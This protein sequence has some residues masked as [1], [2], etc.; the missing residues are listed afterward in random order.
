MLAATS[1]VAEGVPTC[2]TAL[3]LAD[4]QGVEM[5]IFAALQE[6]LDGVVPVAE[7]ARLLMA[8]VVCDEFEGRGA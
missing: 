7:A 4:Q 3:R 6:V 8:R 2:R 5:P 1:Q